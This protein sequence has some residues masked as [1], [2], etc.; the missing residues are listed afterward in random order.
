MN[1][2]DLANVLADKA[3]LTKKNALEIVE[4]VFDSIVEA[5]ENGEEVKIANFGTF[6]IKTRKEHCIINS[7]TK[8]RI[9][10]DAQ[11]SISFHASKSVKK[12]V[13]KEKVSIE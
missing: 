4:Q 12:L 9:K 8:N 13:N 5:L 6:E 11:K 3:R 10:I 1:K 2:I 7:I